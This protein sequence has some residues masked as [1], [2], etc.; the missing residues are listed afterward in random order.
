MCKIRW[1]SRCEVL[2]VW[3]QT[4]LINITRE[5]GRNGRNLGVWPPQPVFSRAL[6]H[7][8]VWERLLQR[9][10]RQVSSGGG[11][12]HIPPLPA[13]FSSSHT[14]LCVTPWSCYA[15]G[16]WHRSFP[17][18][19][20]LFP[21]LSVQPTPLPFSHHSSSFINSGYSSHPI[22]NYTLFL[23]TNTP[24]SLSPAPFCF[25]RKKFHFLHII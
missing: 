7:A 17:L 15:L 21:R 12:T 8:K 2:R 9:K 10:G 24:N 1:R 16:P 4:S 19:R 25:S 3:T 23:P 22:F 18:H 13:S 6:I 11:L 14:E 20:T 5:F